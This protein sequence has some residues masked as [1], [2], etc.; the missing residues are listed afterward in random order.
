MI[1]RG[2]EL[3]AP[4]AGTA[5]LRTRCLVIDDESDTATVLTYHLRRLGFVTT[6]AGSGELAE[7]LL[8]DEAWDLVIV[9]V[10]LPDVDGR[11]LVPG[12]RALDSHPEVI[13]TSVL[14][15]GDL[16]DHAADA[17]LSKPFRGTDVFAAVQTARKAA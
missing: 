13:L 5:G 7:R 1:H 3:T 2:P 8:H 16:F 4:D 10:V 15:A 14:S 9:D 6:V 12:I 17:L 11:D